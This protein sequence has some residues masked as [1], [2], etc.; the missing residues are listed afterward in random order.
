MKGICITSPVKPG[1]LYSLEAKDFENFISFW[2][3]PSPSQP[4]ENPVLADS[5]TQIYILHLI[6]V[7]IGTPKLHRL[8]VL[9]L[10]WHR[11]FVLAFLKC[12]EGSE[13]A[14]LKWIDDSVLTLLRF[15]AI[16]SQ[17]NCTDRELCWPLL[18]W[19]KRNKTT[20]VKENGSSN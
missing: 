19:K 13:L 10:Y 7:C 12:I 1:L 3:S 14:N 2:T 9:A 20:C 11:L 4:K 17:Q 5:Y 16:F 8:S 15:P 6:G 18:V